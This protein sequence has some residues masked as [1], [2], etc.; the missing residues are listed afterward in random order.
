M[1][2]WDIFAEVELF[3]L[4]PTEIGME[5]TSDQWPVSTL[6]LWWRISWWCW[7]SSCVATTSVRD[8]VNTAQHHQYHKYQ[9]GQTMM[10]L[11]L[12]SSPHPAT[13]HGQMHS[14]THTHSFWIWIRPSPSPLPPPR[15]IFSWSV[16]GR[17]LVL[18]MGRWRI[19]PWEPSEHCHR[20][21]NQSMRTL[22][23]TG[24]LSCDNSQ[25]KE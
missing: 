9:T 3:P 19:K 13:S 24:E 7:C 6:S 15:Q 21:H 5:V 10:T 20:S 17:W 14:S 1:E 25:T 22:P 8:D 12:A 16:A 4:R 23:R 11:I 2:I 18:V